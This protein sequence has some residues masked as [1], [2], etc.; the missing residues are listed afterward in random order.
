MSR[1]FSSDRRLVRLY[2]LEMVVAETI[3]WKIPE[4]T[5]QNRDAITPNNLIELSDDLHALN[6]RPTS[7]GVSFRRRKWVIGIASIAYD[8]SSPWISMVESSYWTTVTQTYLIIARLWDM[9]PSF[10]WNSIRWIT[11]STLSSNSHSN[12]SSS[13]FWH[14]HGQQLFIFR[15]IATIWWRLAKSNFK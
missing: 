8:L 15:K 10:K 1:G 13:F 6:S 14:Q 9:L 7:K 4:N 5:E 12:T 11:S 2:S 3:C